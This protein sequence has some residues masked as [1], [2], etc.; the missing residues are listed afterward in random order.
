MNLDEQELHRVTEGMSKNDLERIFRISILDQVRN[1]R[2]AVDE[3]TRKVEKVGLSLNDIQAEAIKSDLK[4]VKES[5][6]NL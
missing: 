6:A 4:S 1:L 3:L 5:L 2:E